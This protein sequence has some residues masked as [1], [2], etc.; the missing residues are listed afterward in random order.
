MKKVLTYAVA[1]MAMTACT[2]KTET[3]PFLTE[4]ETPYGI[5][6]FDKIGI[7]D[8]VPA[9]KAGIEQQ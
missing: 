7:A 6:P 2:T 3:N 1:I 4:W 5:P 9:V 8:F